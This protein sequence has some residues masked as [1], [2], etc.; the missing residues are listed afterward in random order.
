MLPNRLFA[1]KS[2]KLVSWVPPSASKVSFGKKLARDAPINSLAAAV[3]RSPSATS[4]RLRNTS[5][6]TARGGRGRRKSPR[7][8]RDR[9]CGG[10][11]ADQRG[12]GILEGRAIERKVGQL[13]LG[14]AQLRLRPVDV[15][16]RGDV[17]S[18]PILGQLQGRTVDG[19]RIGKELGL[20][21]E[22]AQ[23]DVVAR[24]FRVQLEPARRPAHPRLPR[25]SRSPSARDRA[26]VPRC[27][28]H[29]PLA[30]RGGC[31]RNRSADLA[32]RRG[33]IGRLL[34]GQKVRVRVD[35]RVGGAQRRVRAGDR[36]V[37]GGDR[38]G[39]IGVGRVHLR[40]EI[41]EGSIVEGEPP[42]PARRERRRRRRPRP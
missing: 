9:K 12:D 6:G 22:A 31:R 4:G 25:P 2:L 14:G 16:R 11:L 26:P 24:Q 32:E 34:V 18:E 42:H 27:R 19:D 3:S 10:G 40:L 21:V 13:R 28:P 30:R 7:R 38:G 33:P 39:K 17:R 1:S 29:T 35:L 36:F 15:D 23:I 37:V 41:V 8:P 20:L 5:A